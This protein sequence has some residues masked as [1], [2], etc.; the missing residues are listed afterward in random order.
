MCDDVSMVQN[1]EKA[2][3]SSLVWLVFADTRNVKNSSWT[4]FF[5]IVKNQNI[6]YLLA[7]YPLHVH[8]DFTF[9]S[10]QAPITMGLRHEVARPVL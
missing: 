3:E 8:S 9:R 10:F 7:I 1:E 4:T 6:R 5:Y 2:S